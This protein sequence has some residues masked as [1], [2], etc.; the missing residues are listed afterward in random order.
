MITWKRS[1]GGGPFPRPFLQAWAGGQMVGIIWPFGR[2][3]CWRGKLDGEERGWPAGDSLG[4]AKATFVA[5]FKQKN[6]VQFIQ[7]GE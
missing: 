7:G 3:T 4:E 2:Y 5:K 6:E 1:H